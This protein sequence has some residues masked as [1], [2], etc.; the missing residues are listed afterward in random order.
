MGA[1]SGALLY[2]DWPAPA[3]VQAFCTTR[4]GGVSSGPWASL[5]LGERCGDDGENVR[6]NRSRLAR[7]LPAGPLWLRQV[8]GTGVVRHGGC[9]EQ[10]PEADGAVAFEPGRVCAVLTADC[11]PVFFCDR[12]GT[13]VAVAHAGWRGLAA[14]VLKSTVQA[15]DE[16][17]ANLLAWLGPA[18]GPASYEVGADVVDAFTGGPGPGLAAAFKP[19]GDRWLLDLYAAARIMLAM[20]GVRAVHGGGLCTYR[21]PQRFYSFRRDGAT[22]R[23]ASVI[24]LD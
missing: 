20:A 6:R 12:A 3:R 23:M 18:I 7:R 24:W 16:D 2:P 8:H 22:G 15:L 13:R 9:T 5:N 11:L 17:P 21:D 14:G 1:V 4:D 19:S 10:E